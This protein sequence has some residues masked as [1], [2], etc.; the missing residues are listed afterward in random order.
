MASLGGASGSKGSKGSK[1]PLEGAP[2]ALS[3]QGA[4]G[5]TYGEV[6]VQPV[7]LKYVV[8]E[9]VKRWFEDTHAEAARGDV[10]QQA[11]LGQMYAEGYGCEKD[12]KAA[13]EWTDRAA[14]R[15]YR[16]K[17]VYCEL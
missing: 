6:P 5:Y 9:A 3:N 16:M 2:T 11:L 14:A 12:D 15:G 1:R 10:K 17:G 4:P 8:Q 13:Q 7:P